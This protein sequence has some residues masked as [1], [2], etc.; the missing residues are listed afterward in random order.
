MDFEFLCFTFPPP[1]PQQNDL[2]LFFPIIFFF[3]DKY[4]SSWD[5]AELVFT[6]QASKQPR[7]GIV[8]RTGKDIYGFSP[9]LY[10][11]KRSIWCRNPAEFISDKEFSLWLVQ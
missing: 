1:L 11:E 8:Q 4:T 6:G 7:S 10:M 9:A 2:S 3:K 5:K